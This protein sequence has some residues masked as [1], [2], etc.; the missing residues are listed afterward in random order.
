MG[1]MNDLA[2]GLRF[3]IPAL[4][5]LLPPGWARGRREMSRAS[6][7]FKRTNR[8]DRDAEFRTLIAQANQAMARTRMI[9]MRE[10]QG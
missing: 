6:E 7:M 1:K 10:N 5:F 3:G 4:G 8:P 9:K 2:I